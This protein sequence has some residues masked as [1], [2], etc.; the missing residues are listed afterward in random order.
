MQKATVQVKIQ[1][2][3]V[4]ILF[5]FSSSLVFAAEKLE[6]SDFTFAKKAFNDGFY[7]LAKE[8]LE[9]FLR[10]YPQTPRMYEVHVLLGRCFHYQGNTVLVIEHNL[11]V[12]KTADYIIDLGPEGGDEGGEIVAEGPPEDIVANNRSYTGKYLKQ[13]L[14]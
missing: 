11:D 12:I 10:T 3:I 4:L 14:K 13:V 8:R 9:N 7:D 1:N 6:E 5:L 2:C